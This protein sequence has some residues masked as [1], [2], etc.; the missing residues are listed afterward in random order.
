MIMA[1]S[2]Y[3]LYSNGDDPAAHDN[4]IS[5]MNTNFTDIDEV[6]YTFLSE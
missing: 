5:R 2:T 6:V 1:G 3:A 4:L